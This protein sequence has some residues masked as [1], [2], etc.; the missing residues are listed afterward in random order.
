MIIQY[1][2]I[3]QNSKPYQNS[4]FKMYTLKRGDRKKWKIQI[5]ET[6]SRTV[7]ISNYGSNKCS[8]ILTLLYL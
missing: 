7:N 2:Q 8:R 6:I 3:N 4:I 5:N 1:T